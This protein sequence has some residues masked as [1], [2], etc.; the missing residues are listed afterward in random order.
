V[1]KKKP[2]DSRP[3]GR[4]LDL[5]DADLSGLSP[6]AAALVRNMRVTL[7]PHEGPGDPLEA[8]VDF[9]QAVKRRNDAKQSQEGR[10]KSD[11]SA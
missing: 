11:A 2:D 3:V 9:L 6:E 1:T 4:A 8:V 5:R 7:V 10:G